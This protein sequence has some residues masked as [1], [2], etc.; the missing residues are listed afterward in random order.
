[1]PSIQRGRNLALSC[2]VALASTS[3][4]G[5]ASI[6]GEEHAARVTDN[7]E[8]YAPFNNERPWGPSYLVGPPYHYDGDQN[9]IDDSRSQPQLEPTDPKGPPHSTT[10]QPSQPPPPLP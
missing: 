5:C 2:A 3:F 9:R 4:G 8:V 6:F 1:M 7:F 10:P